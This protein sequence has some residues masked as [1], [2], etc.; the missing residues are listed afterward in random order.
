MT[1]F[2]LPPPPP[3]PPQM[4]LHSLSA[5]SFLSY[6]VEALLTNGKDNNKVLEEQ[7]KLDQKEMSRWSHTLSDP[8]SPNYNPFSLSK[9]TFGLNGK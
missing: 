2:P 1:W 7:E 4:H 3:P 6:G 9:I 5:T 8:M